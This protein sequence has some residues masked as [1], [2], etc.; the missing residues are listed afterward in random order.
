MKK[1]LI[2]HTSVGQGHKTLAENI[3]WHL[4]RAGFKVRLEDIGKVQNGLFSDAV[5]AA[6]WF[7]NRRLPFVWAF[8]YSYGHYV[9]LPFR[10]FIA[11]FNNKK[12]QELVEEYQP[13]L[14]ITTQTTASAV[15]NYLKKKNFY[16]GKFGIAFCDYHLH[17]YWLYDYADFYLA[18]NDEQKQKM[19]VKKI[20]GHKIFVC[21]VTLKPQLPVDVK[22]VKQKF[23]I[24]GEKV[25]LVGTGSLGIGFSASELKKIAQIN[26]TQVII[27][28]GK[29][30]QL[31][32]QVIGL[33]LP[34]VLA[35]GFY[36]PMAELYAIA[37]VFVSKP[38]GLSVAE[39]LQWHLPLLV[40]FTLPGQEQKNLDYLVK[41][42]LVVDGQGSLVDA[43]NS[44]LASDN[45]K[46]QLLQNKEVSKII[47]KSD[48]LLG[49]VKQILK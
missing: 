14:I 36:T 42:N 21:G 1:V 38:G 39:S 27:V 18:N 44:E 32:E 45:F 29:N 7:I 40:S 24:N 6:H 46:G 26:N 3:G 11:K 28:C 23:N 43:I 10:T 34:N 49:A 22:L 2:L 15:V 35:L 8:L 9:I 33:H 16:T 17:P 41:H 4:E 13:D 31:F 5:A 12:T 48:V 20:P 37:D 19:T 25:I 30:E 47:D